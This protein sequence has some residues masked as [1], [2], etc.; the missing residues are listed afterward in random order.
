MT[1]FFAD[2]RTCIGVHIMSKSLRLMVL[3]IIVA[4]NRNAWAAGR[5]VEHAGS[6]DDGRAVYDAGGKLEPW[7]T[8][9]DALQRHMRWKLRQPIEK[10]HALS[11]DELA[12]QIIADV[13]YWWYMGKR[14]E[15]REVML[16]A[17][18][19]G[20]VL[21]RRAEAAEMDGW[22]GMAGYALL[23]LYEAQAGTDNLE[24]AEGIA[25]ALCRAT[26]AGTLNEDRMDAAVWRLRLFDGL[27][28]RGLPRYVSHRDRLRQAMLARARELSGDS[29]STGDGRLAEL[30]E[31]ARY[32]IESRESAAADWRT[33]GEA[34]V[35]RAAERYGRPGAAGVR[36]VGD[37]SADATPA[38]ASC[39][40]CSAWGGVAAMYAAAT[41][42]EHFKD[43]AFRNLSRALYAIDESGALM[44][45]ELQLESHINGT[46]LLPRDLIDAMLT[47][48][49]WS[50]GP[51][52]RDAR[53]V[54]IGFHAAVYNDAGKLVPWIPLGEAIE[55]EM[56][57]YRKCNIES[58]GYP[59][60]VYATFINDDYRPFKTDVIPGC[61][62]GMGILS[63]LKYWRFKGKSDPYLLEMARRQGDYL[64][65]Q[66]L[67]PDEGAYP[68]F[69][70][71]TGDNSDFP[72]NRA[73]QGDLTFGENVIEPDK[74]GIAAY[75]LIE[76][77]DA[78]GDERY[79]SQAV[80]D[81]DC[82][83][84]NMRP[85]TQEQAPWPFRVESVT[86]QHWGER[87][88]NMVFILRSF[89]EL[90]ARG[91]DRYRP[92]REALWRWIRDVQIP[93]PDTR[94]KCHWV[95]F[96]E[97]QVVDDNRT[98]WPALEMARYLIERKEQLD[99]N[100][101]RLAATCIDF[102]LEHFSKWEPGGVTTMCEQDIDL[103]AWGGACAKLGGVAAMFH[104]AG[105]GEAYG[106]MA[107]RNLT[108]MAYHIDA[109]GCPGEITGFFKRLRRAGWQTDCH[110][111]VLHNFVDAFVA[112]PAW[113]D[114]RDHVPPSE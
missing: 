4:A 79:L 74:G 75:A 54:R 83:V 113:V 93:A 107:F 58:H 114:A 55:R 34:C 80:H 17:D 33:L 106:E 2:D 59:S 14:D 98:S 108:W 87:N 41:D 110:C 9:D 60:W 73:S 29:G 15:D 11:S 19:L 103:R 21:Q 47:V 90:I 64:V 105:G 53:P 62:N 1:L 57:W 104:A 95:Q 101:K 24:A 82:L 10:R 45:T 63:Y 100:W 67:T 39:T 48:P 46:C 8:F 97:D 66:C 111:D 56:A 5:A 44:R 77:Y 12:A 86:G 88:G 49:A 112:V 32:L 92:A 37:C 99:P 69:I 31:V 18:E 35:R 22:A 52:H 70:R 96:F 89:D 40:S 85:G 28:K 71:S 61:Q 13:K 3:F 84:R 27:I 109:D 7:T 81:V 102:A 65:E 16:R 36:Y 78:T 38:R 72:L 6:F 76:L 42:D 23:L 50:D 94:D 43:A 68:R 51:R 20:G 25:D 30:V 91:H 26:P